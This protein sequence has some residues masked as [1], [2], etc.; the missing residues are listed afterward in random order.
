MSKIDVNTVADILR[1]SLTEPA[2][3]RQVIEEINRAVEAKSTATAEKPPAGKKQFVIL[4]AD[5]DGEMP[6][7]E[8]A[9][10]VLQLPDDASPL[11]TQERIQ[12][13]AYD[14]NASRAGRKLPVETI[15]QALECVPTKF[16]R[17]VDIAV[18]TKVPVQVLRTDNKLPRG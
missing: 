9:G 3:L 8:L 16:L 18:K 7:T 1:R 15:G 10:W 12:K 17:E 4:I 6:E 14:F 13:A 11:S 5:P 2:Q